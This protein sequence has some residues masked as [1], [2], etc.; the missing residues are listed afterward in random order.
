M[1]HLLRSSGHGI[2][3]WPRHLVS[4]RRGH[5]G[6]V[7]TQRLWLMESS[8][9]SE[10]YSS[11]PGCLFQSVAV[12]LSAPT[13]LKGMRN[14]ILWVVPLH[15]TCH[16]VESESQSENLISLCARWP[17]LLQYVTVRPT[18]THIF[19]VVVFT[20]STA[21]T[22]DLC[23]PEHMQSPI[24]HYFIFFFAEGCEQSAVL[25]RSGDE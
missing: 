25:W 7:V 1:K 17:G 16:A 3:M 11:N 4:G 14:S 24:K 19:N 20:T 8:C 22:A 23:A 18:V 10:L 6:V 5:H 2:K 9:G 13:A 21:R 15:R 12:R